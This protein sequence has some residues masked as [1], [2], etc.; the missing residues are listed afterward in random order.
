MIVLS[1]HERSGVFPNRSAAWPLAAALAPIFELGELGDASFPVRFAARPVGGGLLLKLDAGAL[2]LGRPAQAERRGGWDHRLILHALSGRCSARAEADDRTLE[3][4]DTMLFD[5]TRPFSIRCEAGAEIA[6]LFLPRGERGEGAPAHGRW[7]RAEEGANALIGAPIRLLTEGP[8]DLSPMEARAVVE[9]IDLLAR[10]E[11][12]SA[13]QPLA[14]A[15]DPS[16]DLDAHLSAELDVELARRV[17]D[18]DLSPAKLA[19]LLGLSRSALY[20]LAA[21]DGGVERLIQDA[22]LRHA[23]GLLAGGPEAAP[24]V[25]EIAR[26]SGFSSPAFFSRAFKRRFGLSPAAYRT[27]W[28][29]GGEARIDPRFLLWLRAEWGEGDADGPQ[30]RGAR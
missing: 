21:P 17:E 19:S 6:F 8:P 1:T 24:S 28:Q 11:A 18:A 9:A 4:G 16:C 23:A 5:M 29:A 10:P 13:A 20:R 15:S 26:A 14:R 22:R 30:A 12:R 2:Q 7:L 3:A 27:L 25:G